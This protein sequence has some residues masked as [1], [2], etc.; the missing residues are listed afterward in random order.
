M[1]AGALRGAPHGSRAAR[2]RPEG[3]G[4]WCACP[5]GGGRPSHRSSRPAGGDLGG[6][7]HGRAT[8]AAPCR[9]MNRRDADLCAGRDLSWATPARD[10]TDLPAVGMSG[11]GG[12]GSRPLGSGRSRWR[13]PRGAVLRRCLTQ[14]GELQRRVDGAAQQLAERAL[15]R[16]AGGQRGEH[17]FEKLRRRSDGTAANSGIAPSDLGRSALRRRIARRPAATDLAGRPRKP[18]R[19]RSRPWCTSGSWLRTTR[20]RRRWRCSAG[21]T[22]SST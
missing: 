10:A 20:R 2:R 6:A 8:W 9:A 17:V 13:G 16:T 14:R 11:G 7:A 15:V 12:G 4:A 1:P 21:P 3:D 18:R 5:A 22:R 19:V